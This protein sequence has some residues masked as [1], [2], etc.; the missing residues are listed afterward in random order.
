MKYW[1]QVSR[2]LSIKVPLKTSVGGSSV[3]VSFRF[4]KP[5]IDKSSLHGLLRDTELQKRDFVCQRMCLSKLCSTHSSAF[6]W[7]ELVD[8]KWVSVSWQWYAWVPW[9]KYRLP[10]WV[11]RDVLSS[12]PIKCQVSRKHNQAVQAYHYIDGNEN[13]EIENMY[14]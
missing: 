12:V 14:I 9:S 10:C 1:G 7:S 8:V 4:D 6:V 11:K 3:H 2:F 5:W 13:L